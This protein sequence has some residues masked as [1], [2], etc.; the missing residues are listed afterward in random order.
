MKLLWA[1]LVFV[2]FTALVGCSTANG[3]P[4]ASTPT[5]MAV[6]SASETPLTPTRTS[7]PEVEKASATVCTPTQSAPETSSTAAPTETPTRVPSPEPTITLGPEDW[8]TLPVIP[9]I[10]ENVYQIY[11]R[12]LKLGNDAHSFS[13]IGDCGGTPAWFL[14]DFDR[15]EKFYSLGEYGSLDEVIQY[16]Q[17]SYG[18]TSLAAKSAYNASS[19]FT[20][21]W[22]DPE[23][24]QS[25]ETPLVC[26]YRVHLPIMAIVALGTNDV[27]HPDKFEPQM[28]R[29]IEYSI[30]NGVI[31]IL[32]TKADNLEGDGSINATIARLAYE[33]GIPLWN[34]WRAVQP[35]PDHGLQEDGAHLTWAVN[36]FDDPYAMKSGWTVRNLTALQ[37]LDAVWQGLNNH[38]NGAP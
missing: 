19:V 18:R 12:G 31:P 32:A 13:K 38:T 16:Y 2:S 35:L 14:G 25:G 7:S 9:T 17:G 34:Y 23:L 20:Q 11:R 33:Y 28:R 26:E 21:I 30:D 3:N 15:G 4:Q 37:V 8:K 6:V 22:A 27:Y 5:T 1:G 29:I 24:C 10:S 36:K